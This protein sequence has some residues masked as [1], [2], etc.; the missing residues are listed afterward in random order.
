MKVAPDSANPEMI[1]ISPADG[2]FTFPAGRYAL[3]L[4]K[5]IAYDFSVD[6]PV[7]DKAQCLERTDAVNTPVYTEC[8][9]P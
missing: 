2:T 3:V 4:N 7:S 5:N 1:V 8:R 9:T 6:G